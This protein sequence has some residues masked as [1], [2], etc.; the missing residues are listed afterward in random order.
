MGDG[1]LGF[2]LLLYYGS[3]M[4]TVGL[5]INGLEQ[6]GLVERPKHSPYYRSLVFFFFFFLFKALL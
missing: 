3:A 4:M 2:Q 5:E 6:L 1:E